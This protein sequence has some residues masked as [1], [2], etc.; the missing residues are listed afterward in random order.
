MC[1]K[2]VKECLGYT[3][4]KENKILGFQCVMCHQVANNTI[5]STT[6]TFKLAV[7][8]FL[9][10][11][12][13]CCQLCSFLSL[14][15]IK[16]MKPGLIHIGFALTTGWYCSFLS[17]QLVKSCPL[18]SAECCQLCNYLSLAIIKPMKPRLKHKG[19]VLK[20]WWY[21]SFPSQHLVKYCHFLSAECCQLCQ[22]HWK[23]KNSSSSSSSKQTS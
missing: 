3:N 8:S 9:F 23:Y 4:D 7:H 18:L 10:R 5:T 15:I 21:Y 17:Q 2:S 1:S 19:F 11:L 16:P 13:E 22:V 6:T 12:A 20:P 14:A